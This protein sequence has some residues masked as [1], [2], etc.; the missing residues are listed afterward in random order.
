MMRSV[1]YIQQYIIE[2]RS[3][4]VVDVDDVV[5]DAFDAVV[6]D[7][8]Y[9]IGGVFSDGADGG[10]FEGE[11]EGG[12]GFVEHQ[13]GGGGESVEGE[14]EGEGDAVA[15]ATA[16]LVDVVE[17]ASLVVD[18]EIYQGFCVFGRFHQFMETESDR[19]ITIEQ[20]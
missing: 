16:Y 17:L 6:H 10:F 19:D 8:Q 3:L 15:F 14:G 5:E 2:W 18:C 9:G 20:T 13:E 11:V 4:E 12:E 1:L 7:D